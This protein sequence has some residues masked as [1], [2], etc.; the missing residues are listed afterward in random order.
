M[1]YPESLRECQRQYQLLE[2]VSSLDDEHP[3]IREEHHHI[4]RK[5]GLGQTLEERDEVTESILSKREVK[6]LKTHIIFNLRNRFE[7]R[8][9]V[10]IADEIIFDAKRILDKNR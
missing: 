5:N 7:K 1:S 4:V 3:Y 2:I 8:G 6:R 9:E 10:Y